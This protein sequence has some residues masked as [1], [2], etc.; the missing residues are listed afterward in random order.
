MCEPNFS[1][2]CSVH[3][4][5]ESSFSR[6]NLIICELPPC[7][8]IRFLTSLSFVSSRAAKMTVAPSAARA[9]LIALPIPRFAPVTIA[10]LFLSL[11][12]IDL[13]AKRNPQNEPGG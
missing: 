12:V 11:F 5:M 9:I 10:I 4:I 8:D 2:I 13:C 1:F 7:C 6:S 3:L